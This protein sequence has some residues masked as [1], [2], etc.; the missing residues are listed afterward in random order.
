LGEVSAR[1][2][3]CHITVIGGG[4]G[5][6]VANVSRRPI[7][8]LPLNGDSSQLAQSVSYPSEPMAH[9]AILVIIISSCR[10]AQVE[11]QSVISV[12]MFPRRSSA[13]SSILVADVSGR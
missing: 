4:I 8:L 10:Q 1:D 3:P 13:G 6:A 5:L 7:I 9:L 11:P 2:N 12:S